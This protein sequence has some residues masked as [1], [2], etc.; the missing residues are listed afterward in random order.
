LRTT[1]LDVGAGSINFTFL[2]LGQWPEIRVP[3]PQPWFPS[4]LICELKMVVADEKIISKVDVAK[5]FYSIR[6]RDKDSHFLCTGTSFDSFL[7]TAVHMV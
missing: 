6:E 1:V 3:V 7:Y 5:A 2:E 4:S